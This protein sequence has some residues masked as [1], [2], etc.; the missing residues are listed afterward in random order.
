MVRPEFDVTLAY[1]PESVLLPV[2]RLD[3]IAFTRSAP[4]P[5]AARSSAARA[6]WCAWTAA[7]PRSGRRAVRET[8]QRLGAD[9]SGSS[10]AAQWMLL[11]QLIDEARGRIPPGA[12]LALLTP[13]GRRRWRATLA[14]A[15]ASCSTSTAPPTSASCCAGRSATTCASP[16][17]AA[18]KPGRSAP[19]LAAA[20]CRCSSIRCQP[21]VVLR[22]ARRDAGQRRAPARGVRGSPSARRFAQRAQDAPGRRQCGGQRHALGRRAGRTHARA[23]GGARRGRPRRP[24]RARPARRPGAVGRRSARSQHPRP[25]GLAGRQAMPMRCRQTELRDRYLRSDATREGGGL[26]RAYPAVVR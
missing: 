16:S 1:N 20:Q 3:G 24:H 19:E 25:A 18:P 7:P 4:A 14:A 22:P 8:G 13:A 10:R 12:D 21:A 11:D 23:G 17:P 15:A 5:P 2:A 6:A 26:P 9:L